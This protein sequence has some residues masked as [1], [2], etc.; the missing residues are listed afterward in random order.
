MNRVSQS[1][2]LPPHVL[3]RNAIQR[4]MPPMGEKPAEESN[5]QH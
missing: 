5:E 1:V 4:E 2:N 3:D